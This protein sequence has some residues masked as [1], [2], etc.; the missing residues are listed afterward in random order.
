M[1]EEKSELSGSQPEVKEE[2][3]VTTDPSTV[4]DDKE[5]PSDSEQPWHKDPRFKQD[6]KLLKIAK[7]LVDENGL[8]DVE[9]LKDLVLSGKKVSGKKVDL[10]NLDEI[11][12][13]AQKLD[14]VQ[15]YWDQQAKLKQLGQETPDQSIARLTRELEEVENERSR[16]EQSEA[17]ARDLKKAVSFYESEVKSQLEELED[18]SP[19]EKNFLAFSLGINNECNDINI[20]DK[21]AIKKVLNDGVKQY[22]SLVKAITDKAIKEYREGKTS[23][24]SVPPT[25]G[26]AATTKTEPTLKSARE[27]KAAFLEFLTKGSSK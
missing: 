17:E 10:D 23:I 14:Q 16:Q 7:S 9:E 20:T 25:D 26:A 4:K 21:R 3:D 13:K 22:Q 19:V 27:R 18:L 5:K 11:V 15:K 1:P 12:A 8:E 24:P 6:L 2:K